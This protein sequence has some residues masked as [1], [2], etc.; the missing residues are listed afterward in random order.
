MKIGLNATCLN[1]RASGAKQRFIGINRALF[2]LLPG[3]EFFVFEPADCAIRSWFGQHPNVR[4]VRTP[5]LSHSRLQK[6]LLGLAYW[7][8]ALRDR[9]LDL[10]EAFHL[11]VVKAPRGRTLLTVH[12]VRF[13]RDPS[14]ARAAYRL[15]LERSLH[16]ADHVVTVSQSMRRE[17]LELFPR[18]SI[19]VVY[20]GIDVASF[21]SLSDAQVRAVQA[22]LRLPPDFLLSVGHF[23]ERKN[24][25]GLLRGLAELHARGRQVHL[26]IVGNDSG[27]LAHIRELAA[28]LRLAR[29]ITILDGLSDL[30]VR[31]LYRLCSLFVFPSRYEGFGIPVLEAM[32]AN[33]PF[34]LSDIAVFREI[35]E[36]RAIYFSPDDPASIAATVDRVLSSPGEQEQLIAYGSKRVHDFRFENS[37]AALAALYRQMA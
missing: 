14:P 30:Q 25:P 24:Y 10:F 18:L 36:D 15:V 9:P 11:P 21:T 28:S 37:A 20:N 26:V 1:D 19:S 32:A 8:S 5:L 23:E 29:H 17:I 13:L 16:A 7:R 35:T 12:D 31:C 27:E 3:D 4:F 22:D 6:F 33:R 34:V 2:A